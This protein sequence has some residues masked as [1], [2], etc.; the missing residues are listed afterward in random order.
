MTQIQYL[1]TGAAAPAAPCILSVI[2]ML[3]EYGV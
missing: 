3:P 1:I 2:E